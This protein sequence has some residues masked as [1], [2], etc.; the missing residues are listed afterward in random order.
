M[1]VAWPSSTRMSQAS[2]LMISPGA[3]TRMPAYAKRAR[4][5]CQPTAACAG[6]QVRDR[7]TVPLP[8]DENAE[9]SVDRRCT[10]P[11]PVPG[12]PPVE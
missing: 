1:T 6:T 7:M 4:G 2:L 11:R 5:D 3:D 9:K 10:A 12:V 8:G